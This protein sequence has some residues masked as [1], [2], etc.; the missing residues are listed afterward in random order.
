MKLKNPEL[1]IKF[2]YE[3][4]NPELWI[5]FWLYHTIPYTKLYLDTVCELAH[6][7]HALWEL[8]ERAPRSQSSRDAQLVDGSNCSNFQ[9]S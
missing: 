2:D 3:I 1:W 4:K 6:A 8:E 5:K 9:D 7:A